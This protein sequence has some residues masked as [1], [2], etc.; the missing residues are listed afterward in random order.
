MGGEF[1]PK[2][3]NQADDQVKRQKNKGAESTGVRYHH[4]TTPAGVVA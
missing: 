3:P 2:V 1:F 4:Q